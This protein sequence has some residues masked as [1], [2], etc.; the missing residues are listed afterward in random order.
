[1][2]PLSA[3]LHC[4]HCEI[5]RARKTVKLLKAVTPDFISPTASG[6]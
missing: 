1:V 6:H 4:M 3:T 5:H 2:A